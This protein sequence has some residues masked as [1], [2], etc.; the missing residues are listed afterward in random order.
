[1][2]NK[3]IKE[4]WIRSVLSVGKVKRPIHLF[5]PI[6]KKPVQAFFQ[7]ETVVDRGGYEN[8]ALIFQLIYPVSVSV[9]CRVFV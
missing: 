7:I 2:S 5:I 6:R 9:C 3:E 1:M 8:D 4:I